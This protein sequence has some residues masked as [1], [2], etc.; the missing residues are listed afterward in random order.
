M[1][2]NEG[3]NDNGSGGSNAATYMAP[4]PNTAEPVIDE[5]DNGGGSEQQEEEIKT[6][7]AAPLMDVDTLAKAL[8]AAGLGGQEQVAP[9]NKPL[10]PEQIAQ[11]KKELKF[12][13]PTPDFLTKFNNL[14][15]QE[16]AMRDW[17]DGVT[18]QVSNMM[19]AYFQGM[20]PQLQQQFAPAMQYVQQQQSAQ[21]EDRFAKT[22]PDVAKPELRPLFEAVVQHIK[23]TGKK[24]SG[25]GELFKAV[26]E[27]M[28]A[29]IKAINPEFKLSVAGSSPAPKNPNAIRPSPRGGAGGNGSHQ[30][31]PTAGQPLA[32]QLLPKIRN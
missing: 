29:S 19:A 2:F 16:A 5:S 27:G 10:T 18:Q 25:E 20:V 30:T 32:V 9:T 24:F 7:P 17:H 22:Y 4:V 11:Y 8:K 28:A 15:T 26:A 31:N 1:L 23:G 13:E 12:W 21:V 14:E 3:E 6:P